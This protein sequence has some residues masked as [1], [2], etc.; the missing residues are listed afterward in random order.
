MVLLFPLCF[1]IQSNVD[2]IIISIDITQ[3]SK[4]RMF[5]QKALRPAQSRFVLSGA[6]KPVRDSSQI[7]RLTFEVHPNYHNL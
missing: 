2:G 6:A 4:V 7:Q 3:A 1:E 5:R